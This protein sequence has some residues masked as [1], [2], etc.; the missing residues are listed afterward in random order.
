MNIEICNHN[1]GFHM[2]FDNAWTVSVQF[3]AGSYSDA[4]NNN[5]LTMKNMETRRSDNAEIAAWNRDGV[6]YKFPGDK[7]RG[8]CSPNEIVE[9]MHM[10]SQLPINYVQPEIEEDD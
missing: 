7:V 5:C 10:I 2:K 1:S 9:F 6:W 8:Y 4:R 3:H